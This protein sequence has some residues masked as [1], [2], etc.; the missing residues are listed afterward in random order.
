MELRTSQTDP[1]RISTLRTGRGRIGMTICPGKIG[2]SQSGAPWMRD[3][4]ADLD[5]IKENGFTV[6]VTLMEWQ[7]LQF[8]RVPHIGMEAKKRGLR[9]VNY[10]IVDRNVPSDEWAPA[11]KDISTILRK[12]IDSFGGILVHCLGGLG[13]TGTV[14]SMLLQD[15]GIPAETSVDQIRSARP[16]AI[17]NLLQEEFVRNYRDWV[18][19]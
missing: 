8:Y 13:R 9:W 17:E 11:W 2:A 1:L 12:E 10:P 4:G 5:L 18:V 3:L 15:T 6:V 14:T 19:S 7:E 16:G